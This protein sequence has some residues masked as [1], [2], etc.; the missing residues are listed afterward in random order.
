MRKLTALALLV[1]LSLPL[2]LPGA[3]A[4][5]FFTSADD[6]ALRIAKPATVTGEPITLLAQ[7]ETNNID[8]FQRAL[9]IGDESAA[10]NWTSVGVGGSNSDALSQTFD[11]AAATDANVTGTLLNGQWS[12]LAHGVDFDDTPDNV[13]AVGNDPPGGAIEF[14]SSTGLGAF[15]TGSMDLIVLGA[16][17]RDPALVD[18]PFNGTIGLA[19][20]WE[21]D[22]VSD[23][24]WRT[25]IVQGACWPPYAG[26][27][28]FLGF[29][30][31]GSFD[32]ATGTMPDVVGGGQM[33]INSG[34]PIKAG[35]KPMVPWPGMQ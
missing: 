22:F 27:P 32:D 2:A 20:I 10:D 17:L 30:V 13:L 9:F 26:H 14:A 31:T 18:S 16:L 25:S 8:V 35:Q 34:T 5:V 11:D 6:D 7:C 23:T 4:G 19:A 33:T 12:L 24:Q 1:I 28:E 15:S 3:K 29:F 21:D